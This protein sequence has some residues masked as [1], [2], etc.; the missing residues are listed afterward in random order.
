M[1]SIRSAAGR[2][3]VRTDRANRKIQRIQRDASVWSADRTK[4]LTVG[5]RSTKNPNES[6]AESVL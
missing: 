1:A 5:A 4:F 2:R 6:S 3:L